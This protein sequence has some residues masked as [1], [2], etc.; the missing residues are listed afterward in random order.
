MKKVL[1][2]LAT[3]RKFGASPLRASCIQAN[4]RSVR[5]AKTS[6]GKTVAWSAVPDII[7]NS[8]ETPPSEGPALLEVTS[9]CKTFG[10]VHPAVLQLSSD[11]RLFWR[12]ETPNNLRPSLSGER[13]MSLDIFLEKRRQMD[14]DDRIKLAVNL[15]SSLL[16]Y[17]LTPWLRGCWTKSAVHFFVQT[18]NVSGIDAEHP[19]I[20]KQFHDQATEVLGE[21]P[22]NDPELALMELGILLLEIWNMRTFESWLESAGHLIDVSQ[23]QD[24]YTRLRY[25]IEWFQSLKGKLLPNYQK[26]VGICLRPSVFDLFLTSW[27]DTDFRMAVYREIVEPLLI[28]NN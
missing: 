27:E 1:V 13:T 26:V 6:A 20:I 7:I 11:N 12:T 9:I 10:E 8:N 5:R 3:R 24:R 25:S 22:E 14:P 2:F 15:A 19:L 16:Q 28:W 17:N 21:I 4:T 18:R 23:L